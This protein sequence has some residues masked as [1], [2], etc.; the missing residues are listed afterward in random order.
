MESIFEVTVYAYDRTDY[1]IRAESILCSSRKAAEDMADSLASIYVK[2]EFQD[3][4]DNYVESDLSRS[5]DDSDNLVSIKL[6]DKD[7]PEV[8][9]LFIG[10]EQKQIFKNVKSYLDDKV[11]QN[12]ENVP[13]DELDTN[14][15]LKLWTREE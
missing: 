12:V 2:N 9:R 3:E 7:I 11:K 1:L 6:Q 5:Y 13:I 15:K 4:W 14:K 8:T 10:V